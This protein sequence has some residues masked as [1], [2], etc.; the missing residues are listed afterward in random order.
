MRCKETQAIKMYVLLSVANKKWCTFYTG[1]HLNKHYK[2]YVN[3][4]PLSLLQ[5]CT[6]DTKLS[7]AFRTSMIQL[8]F[9]ITSLFNHATNGIPLTFQVIE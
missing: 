6:S 4:C 8:M 3:E 9:D 1:R 2:M 5:K 7:T